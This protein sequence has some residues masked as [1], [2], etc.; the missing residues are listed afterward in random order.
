MNCKL[1]CVTRR[2]RSWSSIPPVQ[3]ILHIP[4]VPWLIREQACTTQEQQGSGPHTQMMLQGQQHWPIETSI[5]HVRQSPMKGVVV[6]TTSG[7]S[8][9]K[10]VLVR[11]PVF[12]LKYPPRQ[13]AG[14]R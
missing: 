6:V 11:H 1:G 13:T 14:S 3:P 10:G 5:S 2:Q 4:R 12:P 7:N 9:N 8:G